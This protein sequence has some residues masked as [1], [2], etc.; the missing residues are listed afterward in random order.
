ME[1]LHQPANPAQSENDSRRRMVFYSALFG[2]FTA[3]FFAAI[4]FTL[5]NNLLLAWIELA[6]GGVTLVCTVNIRKFRSVDQ[7]AELV[8]SLAAILLI[9]LLF[10]GG[11]RNTGLYWLPFFPAIACFWIGLRKAVWW[12][13]SLLGLT[14]LL[15][16]FSIPGWIK[17]VFPAS[18][19]L[20]ATI[21]TSVISFIISLYERRR[22]TD[23][24]K[25]HAAIVNL[26][27]SRRKAERLARAKDEFLANMS[28]EIRTPLNGV[29]GM[30]NVL[31]QS[32][33]NEGQRESTDIIRDSAS[34]LLSL[35]NN[36]LDF[37]RME[38]GR[39]QLA[40]T[41]FNMQTLFEEVARVISTPAYQKGVEILLDYDETMATH[42]LGDKKHLRQILINLA[43]NAVKFTPSGHVMLR[44]KCLTYSDQKDRVYFEVSDT[45]I[46]IPKDQQDKIFGKFSQ[47]DTSAQRS[48]EGSG[49][50]L[51]ISDRLVQMMGDQIKITSQTNQGSAFSFEL[52]LEALPSK[53]RVPAQRLSSRRVLV[54]CPHKPLADLL[55][56]QLNTLGAGVEV[57]TG[58]NT[59]EHIMQTK[60]F[61]IILLD[62]CLPD[63][64]KLAA[65]I[66][67]LDR[68]T[69][70]L[71]YLLKNPTQVI[72]AE[73]LEETGIWATISKPIIPSELAERLLSH[74][75]TQPARPQPKP[76]K[77]DHLKVL[78]VEDNL[79]NQKVASHFLK[80]FG[81]EVDLASNGREAVNAD[82][83]TRYDLIFMDCQ[84]PEMDGYEA[85]RAIRTTEKQADEPRHVPIIALTAHA[86]ESDRQKCL[87]VGMDDYLSKPIDQKKLKQILSIYSS[88]ICE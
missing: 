70:P 4:N 63:S 83:S 39:L 67:Q 81:C 2:A 15:A 84:M 25:L 37:S 82:F 45:G 87:T 29:I 38:A 18:E 66:Q 68:K 54:V 50:G 13:V 31:L 10:T 9:T 20:M 40:N 71:I 44:A 17:L 74:Y 75:S 8:L 23:S 52:K 16:L 56:H 48:F 62:Q 51:A 46:G 76:T 33:L 7:I 3:L 24:A 1:R 42:F 86:L 85:T 14:L 43:G 22:A 80:N 65:D 21:I 60:P 53:T 72:S 35:I 78:L 6:I 59:L 12:I 47:A 11:I 55:D 69:K 27:E 34:V 19:I 49:L 61:D 41:P 32:D 5:Q 64:L 77:K 79:V 28:H 73:A 58:H 26:D 57:N 30:A 36:V 88:T